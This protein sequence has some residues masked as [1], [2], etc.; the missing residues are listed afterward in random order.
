MTTDTTYAYDGGES[1]L[2]IGSLLDTSINDY[3]S[4][5]SDAEVTLVEAESESHA[6]T[7]MAGARCRIVLVLEDR[8]Y[9]LETAAKNKSIYMVVA[10]D[11]TIATSIGT[12]LELM[13]LGGQVKDSSGDITT[14]GSLEDAHTRIIQTAQY[15]E[16]LAQNDGL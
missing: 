16:F 10:K 9:D 4:L 13:E 11:E 12:S 7:I 14:A 1:V 3:R 5:Y 6:S 15:M 2:V 8:S